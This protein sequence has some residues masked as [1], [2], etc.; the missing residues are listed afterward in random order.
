MTANVNVTRFPNGFV[1]A[2]EVGAYQN[3]A[4]QRP[5]RYYSY[6]DDFFNYTAA[7]WVVTETD[8][9]STE[10]ITS[11]AGGIL[12]ITNVS[13]GATD[14]ASLQWAGGSGAAI[15]PFVWSSTNDMILSA[16]FKVDV[17]ATTSLLIGLASVDTSPVASLPTNGIYFSQIGGAHLFASIRI[18]GA[19]TTVDMGALVD[20][21]Y[22]NCVMFYNSADGTWACYRANALVG[23]MTAASNTPTAALT[24]TIGILN[25]SAAAHVLSVDYFQASVDR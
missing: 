23:T 13:A 15:T 21:T 11:G 7:N 10:I 2:S 24:Q 9:G 5:F 3:F 18:A 25:A 8:A 14:A 16:R 12:A 20:D 22:V 17:A 1:D 6:I 19:S 4:Q